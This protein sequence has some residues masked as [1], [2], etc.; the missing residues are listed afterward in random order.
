MPPNRPTAPGSVV[1]SSAIVWAAALVTIVGIAMPAEAGNFTVTKSA[2]SV[3]D[4]R[5]LTLDSTVAAYGIGING[6][7]FENSAITTVNGW[8]YAVYWVKDGSA[9]HVALAR[10]SILSTTWQ[11]ANLGSSTMTNGL[12]GGKPSDAHNVV[13]MGIDPIDG[14]IHLA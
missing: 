7:S 14:T 1:S 9:Y 8:Q 5:G 13:S 4:S 2:D 3:I 11:V 6:T 10:R 12:S